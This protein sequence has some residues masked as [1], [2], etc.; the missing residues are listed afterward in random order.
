MYELIGVVILVHSSRRLNPTSKGRDLIDIFID[1]LIISQT[2]RHSYGVCGDPLITDVV[3]Y[4]WLSRRLTEQ[5]NT[6][7][8]M[9]WLMYLLTVWL[10]ICCVN[11]LSDGLTEV[12]HIDGVNEWPS[13]WVVG[14]P[15]DWANECDWW[16]D[17]L[18]YLTICY[19]KDWQIN[20]TERAIWFTE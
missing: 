7:R 9:A 14:Y 5:A 10:I 18:F 16:T 13:K 19:V 4:D 20:W 17:G 15:S 1:S 6:Y 2:D 11:V 3:L 8:S 12:L